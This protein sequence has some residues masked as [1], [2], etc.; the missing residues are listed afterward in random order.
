ML[1]RL[2]FALGASV[3]TSLLV[4][5]TQAAAVGGD[6]NIAVNEL[7]RSLDPGSETGNVDVRVYYSI[8]D[9]L[10]RRDFG[11]EGKDGA[12]NDLVPGLATTWGWT[13][14]TTF[15][16]TLREG[17][18]CH[19]GSAFDADDVLATFSAER[20]WGPESY[21]P[22][23]RNY[24]GNLASV[25]KVDAKTVRF[26]T[27][28]PDP[29]LDQRLASYTAFVVC[30]EALEAYH[31][32]GAD[33]AVWL[34]AAANGQ[35]WNPVGTGPYKFAGYEKDSFVRLEAFAEGW[36][37]TPPADSL[38]FRSVP[39]VAARISGLVAGDFDLA[40]DIPSDQWDVVAGYPDLVLKTIPI[41]NSHLLVFNMSDPVMADVKLRK[42]MSLAIDRA[43]L[44]KALWKD[45]TYTPNGLQ[46][47]SFGELYDADRA[48]YT[49]DPEAAKALLAESSYDGQE[50][51]YRLIPNY[52]IYNVE[53]AQIIQEMW[54]AVGINVRIDFVESFKEVRAEGMQVHA[55]SNTYRIPDP[56]GSILP[57]YGPKTQ[58]QDE[59]KH[60]IAP[61]EF[62]DLGTAVAS[63]TD[64]AKR[65][66]DFQ[67]MLD[68]FDE[69]MPITLLFNPVM[70]YAM[71]DTLQWQPYSQFYMDFGPGNLTVTD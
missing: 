8:F 62:N 64:V 35:R 66:A 19:D 65:R 20:L 60:F 26:V 56:T 71:K 12:G 17:V 9:T 69:E 50:I 5:A 61:Q 45:Q 7:P 42:A 14:D 55:W 36:Q 53:V 37:G 41:E 2:S 46:L 38:T 13:D 29:T 33:P 4:V 15:E 16:V 31:T 10:I 47:P 58:I 40:V 43:T 28:A 22:S 59:Y 23:G 11:A 34:E 27:T 70:A 49:Y 52:Y 57:L 44:I 63:T 21:Y 25:D 39:E 67:R 1:K 18:M 68:I 48:G 30:N 24:F 51:S 3:A 54:R 32:E 6:L